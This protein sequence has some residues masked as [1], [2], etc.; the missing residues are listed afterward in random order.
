MKKTML[1]I[2]L[3]YTLLPG[4]FVVGARFTNS[5]RISI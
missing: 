5:C 4:G 3:F 2:A 1:I